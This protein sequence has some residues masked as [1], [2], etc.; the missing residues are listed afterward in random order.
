MDFDRTSTGS[1]DR[2]DSLADGH[3]PIRRRRKP[4]PFIPFIPVDFPPMLS[5]SCSLAFP[6]TMA[7]SLGRR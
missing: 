5:R 3:E 7:V 2:C 6:E 1:R 4:I